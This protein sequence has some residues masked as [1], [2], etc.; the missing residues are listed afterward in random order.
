M[1][2]AEKKT[3]TEAADS[4]ALLAIGLRNGGYMSAADIAS[5]IDRHV[6]QLRQARAG[7]KGL[8]ASASLREKID[9]AAPTKKRGLG[10]IRFNDTAIVAWCL[11]D[12]KNI[13]VTARKINDHCWHIDGYVADTL[14]ISASVFGGKHATLRYV[15]FIRNGLMSRVM[16][17]KRSNQ[18]PV[19]NTTEV[20]DE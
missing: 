14:R 17:R 2:E 4:L 19:T 5:A 6:G 9:P 18:Q 12:N 16:R 8:C 1:N 11:A 10:G 13:R 3:I 20:S 15:R 7:D